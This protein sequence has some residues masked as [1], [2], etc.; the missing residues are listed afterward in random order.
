QQHTKKTLREKQAILKVKYK[1][2]EQ[3]VKKFNIDFPTNDPVVCPPFDEMKSLSLADRFWDVGQLTHPDQPWAVDQD[4][5]DGIRA[6]LDMTHTR[7]ELHRI[8]RECRQ[9]INWALEMEE[10]TNK[11][12]VSVVRSKILLPADRLKKS[13]QILRSLHLRNEQE[14]ARL[15]IFWN[16]GMLDLLSKT[17]TYC[18]L[19]DQEE[20][21]LKIRWSNLAVRSRQ[22]WSSGAQAEIVD[23]GPLDED[24]EAQLFLDPGDDDDQRVD[25]D[26][27]DEDELAIDDEGEVDEVDLAG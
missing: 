19:T 2:F 23:A 17:K 20:E 8:A 12:I 22:T 14:L 1:T 15:V 27:Q 24:E 5:Q 18:Q 3:N 25:P 13:R 16:C 7:D 4:T 10:K 11:W 9:C 21:D 6:Y 26:E